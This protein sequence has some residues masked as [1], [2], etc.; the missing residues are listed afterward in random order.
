MNDIELISKKLDYR[1]KLECLSEEASELAKASL[2][3]IRASGLSNNTTPVSEL[4]S[5]DNLVEEAIDVCMCLK[6]LGCLPTEAQI[7]NSSKW[8]RWS[9][10]LNAESRS[11][12]RKI[13]CN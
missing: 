3:V 8:K 10:R 12:K 11:N 9:T 13:Y 5:V 6:L 4:D 1:T 2:K 7:L